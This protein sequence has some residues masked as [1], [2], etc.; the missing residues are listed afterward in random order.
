MSLAVGSDEAIKS[1]LSED[2]QHLEAA[3]N[4]PQKVLGHFIMK[5]VD[6]CKMLFNYQH[7]AIFRWM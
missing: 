6:R 3:I 2:Q 7:K 4:A 5:N 1:N